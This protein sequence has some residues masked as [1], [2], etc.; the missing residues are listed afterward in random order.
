MSR[1][2]VDIHSQHDCNE[3]I[4]MYQKTIEDHVVMID[5]NSNES[6]DKLPNKGVL[7]Q[8]A[9]KHGIPM[10]FGSYNNRNNGG[11]QYEPKV[12][13]TLKGHFGKVYAMQWSLS[14]PNQLVS[15]AQD[16]K[17]IVWN[18]MTNNKTHMIPLR[19]SWVMTCAFSKSGKR[20]ACGGLDNICSI[21]NLDGNSQSDARK[22][23][24]ELLAHEGYLSHC[25]FVDDD[26]KI[27]TS[28][29][30]Q[31]CILWDVN[32]K[33]SEIVFQ[34]HQQDVMSVAVMYVHT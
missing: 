29:G 33:S 20:V 11:K 7:A 31:T 24:I 34:G 25:R 3:M 1:K 10:A 32:K 30:D 4:R 15:A 5:N 12:R 26:N 16:G 27:L 9:S 19:S 13:Q 17:L 6:N 28:S 23:D 14:D 18:A 8:Q 21:Y 22:A 2:K